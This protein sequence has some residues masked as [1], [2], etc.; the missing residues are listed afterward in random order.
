MRALFVV[1]FLAALFLLSGRAPASPP[2]DFS[3]EDL[4]TLQTRAAQ[5]DA[6]AQHN[7]GVLYAEGRGVPQDHVMARQWY[8]QAA[9]QGV[10]KAQNNLGM[11]YRDGQGRTAQ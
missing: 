1:I 9:A 10:A 4:H 7:L 2:I 6:Q 5:G 3:G 8:E 11:L